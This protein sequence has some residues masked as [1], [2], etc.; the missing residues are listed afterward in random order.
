ML[1]LK[2]SKK[3]KNKMPSIKIIDSYNILTHS[4]KNLCVT[5][6][7]SVEKDIFPYNFVTIDTLFYIGIKPSIEYYDSIKEKVERYLYNSIPLNNWST[8]DETFKY[9]E[10]DLRSLYEVISKFSSNIFLK[11]NV[12]VVSCLTI[13]SVAMKIFLNKFYSENIP[14][15]NKR[16][17][18]EDIK[19]SYFGGVTEIYRPYGE[20]LYYY[21]VNSLYPYAAL[22][23]MPGVNCVFEKNINMSIQDMVNVFG[24]FYCRIKNTKDSYLGLLPVKTSKGIIMPK[25]EWEGWYFSEELKLAQEHG[26]EIKVIKGY[27]FDKVYN[28]FNKFVETLYEAKTNSPDQVLRAISKSILNNLIGRLGLNIYKPDTDLKNSEQFNEISQTKS[29]TNFVS[30]GNKYLLSY[31]NKVSKDICD[32]KHQNDVDYKNT[33]LN[34]IKS[35]AETEH[36]F[37]DVSIAIASAVTSYARIFMAKTKLDLIARGVKIYYTDTDSLVINQPLAENLVGSGLGQFKLEYFVVRGYFIQSKT[38]CLVL[39]D[40]KSIIKA[41]GVTIP[42][43]L[44]DSNDSDFIKLP[45]GKLVA[46]LNEKS[47]VKLLEGY[48]VETLRLESKINRSDGYVNVMIPKPITLHGDA[49][50]QRVR[51]YVDNKWVDTK[52]LVIKEDKLYTPNSH[53]PDDNTSP[54]D[55]TDTFSQNSLSTESSSSDTTNYSLSIESS[56]SD[57]TDSITLASLRTKVKNKLNFMLPSKFIGGNNTIQYNKIKEDLKIILTGVVIVLLYLISKLVD[58]SLLLSENTQIEDSFSSEI[59]DVSQQESIIEKI[60]KDMKNLSGLSIDTSDKLPITKFEHEIKDKGWKLGISVS[61]G[62]SDLDDIN[63]EKPLDNT[64]TKPKEED[65]DENIMDILQLQLLNYESY[66]SNATIDVIQ[67][68]HNI[69]TPE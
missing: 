21:D 19:L 61:T 45:N 8:Q 32:A 69:V 65:P 64:V 47:F 30:I 13:S 66:V 4:L 11:Y 37:K 10:K 42:K 51:I 60:Y 31:H 24:F 46:R 55:T 50:G 58:D 28:V 57:T 20:D 23:P 1:S 38:Y 49:Y 15:I 67:L 62:T 33:V 52:P 5:F 2:I 56:P 17:I 40:S 29:I 36:T 12:Q 22:N 59:D 6:A 26:Y 35:G 25:G 63:V 41:K 27:H 53:P 39:V 68:N 34:N 7:T 44:I 16:S 3:V 14:L 48:D 9:L 54:S 43:D 18:Y